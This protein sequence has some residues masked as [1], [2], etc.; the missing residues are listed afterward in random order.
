MTAFL[1]V[2]F[3]R[4]V[5]YLLVEMVGAAMSSA[6]DSG[7][8]CSLA[9]ADCT[10]FFD[11]CVHRRLLSVMYVVAMLPADSRRDPTAGYLATNMVRR[12]LSKPRVK[13]AFEAGV[14]DNGDDDVTTTSFAVPN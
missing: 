6:I 2:G 12:L 4:D 10:L 11:T 1:L 3:V 9:C 13:A 14:L 7:V 5:T 8:D